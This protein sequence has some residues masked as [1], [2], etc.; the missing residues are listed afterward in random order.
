MSGVIETIL[1]VAR[2]LF[3]LRGQLAKVQQERKAQVTDLLESIAQIIEDANA[4]LQ[5]G[6]YPHGQCEELPSQAENMCAAI[7]DLI[8]I[9]KASELADQLK[10]ICEIEQLYE[11]FSCT[12][13][14]EQA[15]K[16]SA[17][18]QAA[19]LLRATAA[20]VKVSQ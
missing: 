17:L 14:K 15:R 9:S 3:D 18:Y 4:S 7:S 13:Q 20:F 5:E 10:G 1:T 2:K 6:I 19:G 11:E 12:S 16:L 8:G